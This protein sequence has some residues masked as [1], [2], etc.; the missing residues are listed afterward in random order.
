LQVE[1]ER[2]AKTTAQKMLLQAPPSSHRECVD[3]AS[4]RLALKTTAVRTL[5][6]A[7]E[8]NEL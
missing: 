8:P 2:E 3:A 5:R 7:V 1:G 6:L 4:P